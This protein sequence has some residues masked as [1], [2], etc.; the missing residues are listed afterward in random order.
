MNC[1]PCRVRIGDTH[2]RIMKDGTV[3]RVEPIDSDGETIT[4]ANAAGKKIA[5]WRN[6]EQA[7]A[8]QA[9]SIRK[10]AARLRANRNARERSQVMRELGLKR[11]RNGQWE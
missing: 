5:E 11:T 6:V 1:K 3:F 4:L 10:H 9:A 8:D 2:Y 7:S